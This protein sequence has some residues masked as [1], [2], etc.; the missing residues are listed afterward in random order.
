MGQARASRRRRRAGSALLAFACAARMALSAGALAALPVA[1]VADSQPA[2]RAYEIPAGSLEDVLA[3]FGHEAGILLSFRPELTA[4][5]RSEGLHGQY[6]VDDG[7]AA[8]LAGAGILAARQANGSYMLMRTATAA[9]HPAAPLPP[10]TVV[11]RAEQD[12]APYAGGQVARGGTL[13]VLGTDS[14]MDV[15][16]STM[17]YTAR[18]LA[19]QQART[20]A[21][22]VMN[23][24][25]VRMLTSTGGFGE[26]YQIRGYN[27]SSGDVGVNGLFGLASGSRMPAMIAERVEVLKGPGTLMN[28]ISPGGSIGGSINI[29]TKRAGDEPLTRLSTT[30]QSGNQ[31]GMQADIGRRFGPDNAWGVRINAAYR[32]GEG[33]IKGG[34]QDV[35]AG[36]LALDYRAARLRWSLDAYTQRENSRNFRPQVGF[37]TDVASIPQAP[38]ADVNF[39]PDNR[40][41]LNDDAV[42]TRLDY[43]IS[44]TLSAYAALGYRHGA[45]WQNLPTGSVDSNGAGTALNG[46]YDTYSKTVTAD[47]GLRMQL[48]AGG[49]Q[50]TIALGLTRLQQEAGNAYIEAPATNAYSIYAQSPLTPITAERTAPRKSYDMI[51]DSLTLTDSMSLLEGRLRLFAG[52]RRQAVRYDS[53]D[54]IAGGLLSAYNAAAV[55]PLWG[56]VVK[57]DERLSLYAN[58]TA[59]LTRGTV[60]PTGM[61]NVGQIL[62]PYRSRQI[63]AGVKVDWGRL[64]TNVSVFEIAN[65]SEVITNLPTTPT[66]SLFSYDGDQRNRGLE[67]SAYGEALPGLRLLASGTFYDARL[68]RT[69]DGANDGRN[70]PGIPKR[71]FNLAADWDAPWLRGLAFNARMVYTSPVWF[72]AANTLSLPAWTR[73]DI[74][75]RY[76]ARLAGRATVLRLNVE[77][78]FNRNYWLLDNPYAT[79]A[80]PRTVLLSAQ[81]DF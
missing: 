55:S 81:V 19:D 70:A 78:L 68:K 5:L 61:I 32:D 3:R 52:A 77:N 66:T 69:A 18:L 79:V 51:L 42:L 29:V 58:Y 13:G 57:P 63:E 62:P 12:S 47:A 72:N 30:W 24:A 33:S 50:H 10:V 45:T 60:V 40:L 71:T 1:A 37:L 73:W 22:V 76:Q 6:D 21:D 14:V 39:F 41:R 74:G 34:H 75:A 43:D 4:G 26:T 11:S 59:G 56:V 2:V 28:G 48:D 64:A 15:P 31:P 35:G 25:S 67:L 16:F 17:N 27:L 80:A 20:L 65:P 7:L 36:T 44:D 9:A 54:T 46:Y 49:V 23:E 38:A 53:Y 8:L